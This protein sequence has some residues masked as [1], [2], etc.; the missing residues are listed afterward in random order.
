MST[1]TR[2]TLFTKTV[3]ESE[4]RLARSL[5]GGHTLS[6][7][8]AVMAM[9]NVQQAVFDII[10]NKINNECNKL[11]EKASTS[12]FRKIPLDKTVDFKWKNLIDELESKA[13]LLFKILSTIA[14]RN[15]CR[16]KNKVGVAHYPGI[17]TA[18][19]VILKERNR[20]MC[21][22]QSI[23]SLLMY[24]CHCEKQVILYYF[25]YWQL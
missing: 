12:Y 23:L 5:L 19:A 24:V 2:T 16:N 10:L 13:P 9:A 11:C 6:I 8:K 22:I 7:A 4:S 17:C 18:A 15:D 1:P 20:E 14:S 25:H 3:G 21:G